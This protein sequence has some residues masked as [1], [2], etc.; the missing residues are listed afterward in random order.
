MT[1]TALDE[2]VKLI[3][4]MSRQIHRKINTKHFI[5]M[6]THMERTHTVTHR[7]HIHHVGICILATYPHITDCLTKSAW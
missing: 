2:L 5:N 4:C 6:Q 1:Y 3:G 7:E